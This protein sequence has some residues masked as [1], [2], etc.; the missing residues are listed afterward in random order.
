[1]PVNEATAMRIAEAV[2]KKMRETRERSSASYAR[3]R[4]EELN[5]CGIR[6]SEVR[7]AYCS[8]IGRILGQR[9]RKP[10]ATISQVVARSKEIIV[11]L[12]ER[13]D[14]DEAAF[15]A[16]VNAA[17]KQLHVAIASSDN[18]ARMKWYSRVSREL[19]KEKKRIARANAKIR[20]KGSP[21][22]T[23]IPTPHDWEEDS[24]F[25][26][27]QGGRDPSAI[28]EMEEGLSPLPSN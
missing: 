13:G 20:R 14:G 17:L 3:F 26:F 6:D 1:M 19:A 22:R 10:R 7:D 25:R 18:L 24:S 5:R 23:A 28:R 9:P 12:R 16:G 2:S 8:A 11:A 27:L 21:T 4:D 15:Y